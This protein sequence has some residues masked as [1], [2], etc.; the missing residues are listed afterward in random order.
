[1][2]TKEQ[3][4]LWS[5]IRANTLDDTPRLV[6]ADWLQENGDEPRAEF[7]RVQ[8]ALEK[9]GPDRRKHRKQRVALEKYQ[10]ALL[11]KHKDVWLAPFREQM[12]GTHAD[13]P[14]D[15][16]LEELTFRRGFI[17]VYSCNLEIARAIAVA[18]DDI[19]PVDRIDFLEMGMNY[20]HASIAAVAE[21]PGAGCVTCF[22]IAWAADKDARVIVRAGHM[23]N[24]LRLGLWDG[25]VSDKSV[26]QLAAWPGLRNLRALDLQDNPITDAGALALVESPHLPNLT[27]LL[28]HG[29]RI[30]KKGRA[31]LRKRFGD[32]VRI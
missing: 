12:K 30:G 8:C 26:K 28:L 5:A 32:I 6:Y 14:E 7:I 10:K 11:K 1:M 15:T 9:L 4:A 13:D 31:A 25:T 22:S 23:R 17:D 21:W 24:L 27:H 3:C 20:N 18:G 19:E 16:W 2:P 29:T